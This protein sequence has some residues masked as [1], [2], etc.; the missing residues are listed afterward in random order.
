MRGVTATIPGSHPPEINQPDHPL[1]PGAVRKLRS[2]WHGT[3]D[4][5]NDS[6]KTSAGSTRLAT[7]EASPEADVH[8]N[9]DGMA[10]SHQL[11]IAPS[12]PAFALNMPS[13]HPHIATP[14]ATS[15]PGLHG[16]P[17]PVDYFGSPH[18]EVQDGNPGTMTVPL[19]GP[20]RV[21]LARQTSSPL[22]V[23]PPRDP[24]V[25][26]GRV[27]DSSR[28][29]RAVKEEQ[30][31]AELGFLI[32]PNPPDELERRRALYKCDSLA[33]YCTVTDIDKR[34]RYNIWNT[35]PD[36]NFDRIVHLAKLV[37]NTKYAVISMIDSNEQ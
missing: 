10:S 18:S 16:V 27:F 11:E 12:I 5:D 4:V 8:P 24:V 33:L 31:Y 19:S 13:A 21:S 26:G 3:T 36:L 30:A 7:I 15:S 32:P 1:T 29:G 37:F 9:R 2:F 14:P 6:K 17:S 35:G 23:L 34:Y 22:P 28:A 20:R 25:S